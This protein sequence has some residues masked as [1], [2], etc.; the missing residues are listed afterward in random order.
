MYKN[1]YTRFGENKF[2]K[3]AAHNFSYVDY[4]MADTDD[5]LYS[6]SDTEFKEFLSSER[7]NAEK[8]GIEIFQVHGPWR[9]PPKDSTPSERAERL[10]KM[11]KSILA[12]SVLGSKNWVIHPIMPFGIDDM[13]DGKEHE[14]YALNLEFMKELLDFAKKYD[15]NICLENMPMPYF[16]IA[17]PQ[18]ILQFINEINDSNFKACLDTGHISIFP[19]LSVGDSIRMLKDKLQT[20]H[21]HDNMGDG[22]SHIF[23]TEGIIDWHD[24]SSALREIGFNGCFS[25]ET[26]PNPN[27]SNDEFEAECIRLNKIAANIISK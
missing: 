12:T 16:S 15:I 19:N 21:I 14:T 10:C 18:K 5:K 6:L 22:D 9:W 20:L 7:E 3:V 2:K 24:V 23:P 8:A 11:K 13:K 1:A 27:L 25:L 26:L 4:C 17:T